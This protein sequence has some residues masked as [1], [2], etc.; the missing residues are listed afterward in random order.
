MLTPAQCRAARGFLNWT[1][2]DLAVASG[3]SRASLNSF[4]SGNSNL[5][6]DTMA[7]IQQALEAGGI[8]FNETSGVRLRGQKLEVR[9]LE[10]LNIIAE[11]IDDI[12]KTCV[13]TGSEVL[14]AG[15][16]ESQLESIWP[17][18]ELVRQHVLRLRQH[19]IKERVIYKE[20]DR[21]FTFP[22][23]VTTYR[24]IDP[25]LFGLS[26]TI[27]YGNK[28]AI[29]VFGPPACLVI[30]ENEQVADMYRHQF[31]M[32]WDFSKPVPFTTDEIAEMCQKNFPLE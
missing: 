31:E 23:D 19:G 24:W 4:E 27:T 32:L 10:G 3:I 17:D 28:H 25:K 30:T 26:P 9:K 22:P 5:K 21:Y 8:E 20:G 12:F 13:A 14:F 29:V 16:D 18:P 11:L 6:A 7:A 15:H 2:A 1:L